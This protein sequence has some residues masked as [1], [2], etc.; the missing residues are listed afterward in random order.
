MSTVASAGEKIKFTS[1]GV[2]CLEK[3][4]DLVEYLYGVT[5]AIGSENPRQELPAAIKKLKEKSNGT[6]GLL[7]H[8]ENII[9]TIVKKQKSQW[10]G[11]AYNYIEFKILSINGKENSN[12]TSMWTASLVDAPLYKN[13]N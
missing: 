6:C 11:L 10:K 12:R 1:A 13:I 8:T 2:L 9:A 3:N 7:N 5:M 4:P